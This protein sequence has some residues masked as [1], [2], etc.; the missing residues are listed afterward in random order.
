[1]LAEHTA[2]LSDEQTDAILGREREPALPNRHCFARVSGRAADPPIKS[3]TTPRAFETWLSRNHGKTEGIWLVIAKKG[4]EHPLDHVCR[5]RR[6]RAL[7]RLDRRPRKEVGRRAVCAEVHASSRAKPVVADQSQAGARPDRG[8]ANA[9]ARS[10]RDRAGQGRWTMG[11]CVRVAPSGDG[12]RRPGEGLAAQQEGQQLHSTRSTRGTAT[13]SSTASTTRRSRRRANGALLSSSRCS[14]K[15]GSPTRSP[16][17]LSADAPRARHPPRHARDR[18]RR[19]GRRR[20][21]GIGKKDWG[22]VLLSALVY[23]VLNA[24]LGSSSSCSPRRSRS[25][26][27]ASRFSPSMQ[28]SSRSRRGSSTGSRSTTWA[29]RS[30]ARCG[31]PWC[32]SCS[33]SSCDA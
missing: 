25:S 32:R 15:D 13:R 1:M 10:A 22:T 17:V 28:S 8:R 5:C 11:G 14:A 24:T 2:S 23:M 27:S 4:S 7:L 26:R 30:S 18:V 31:S 12:A 16:R 21:R 3:F 29:P 33:S 6:G 9:R 20:P 19:D